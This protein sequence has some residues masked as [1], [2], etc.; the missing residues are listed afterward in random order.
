MASLQAEIWGTQ[1]VAAPSSLLKAMSAAGGIVLLAS[2]RGA[3]VGFAYGFTGR[4]RD[5]RLYHRSHAAGVLP[6]ARDS[7]I[8]RALKLGQ[9]RRATA[10]GLD[11][12]VWTF[13]PGQGRNAHFNLNRLG[14]IGRRF[15]RNY[16]GSRSDLLNKGR[17]S[18]RMVVEWHF[19]EARSRALA[20]PRADAQLLVEVPPALLD[21]RAPRMI[22]PAYGAL[23]RGLEAAF[24]QGAVAVD[25]KAQGYWFAS[26]P[27]GFP[28]PVE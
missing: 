23:R 10:Q 1:E 6:Q 5:G 16:Y 25:F 20:L 7:G 17:P 2:A 22:T 21:P 8:G 3:P 11:L 9:R 13:D 18:D 15:H 27:E 26:L 4:S 19:D 14:A 24:R 12:M 28:P